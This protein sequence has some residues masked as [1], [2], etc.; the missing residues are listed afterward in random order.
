LRV[1]VPAFQKAVE[2]LGR[3]SHFR[4][5]LEAK[6]VQRGYDPS[7]VAETLTRLADRDLIDDRR[8]ARE[9]VRGRLARKA[10]GRPRLAHELRQR[11]VDSEAAE[12][13]LAELY[14]DDDL[15]LARRAARGARGSRETVARRLDR[16][17]FSGRSIVAVLKELDPD[18]SS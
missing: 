1:Q 14:P 8:T 13:A 16:L 4:R 11:G 12:E 18:E 5:E 7:E 9:Y 3:R 17:G 10:L 2:L 6:L 15:D